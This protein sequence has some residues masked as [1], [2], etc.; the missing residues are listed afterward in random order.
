MSAYARESI[1][2]IIYIYSI[3]ILVNW[4]DTTEVGAN[5]LNEGY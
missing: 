1:R 4:M 3:L 5:I 2:N